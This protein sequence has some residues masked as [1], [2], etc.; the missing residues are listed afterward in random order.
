MGRT[1][2]GYT[3]SRTRHDHK[4]EN[5]EKIKFEKF[6]FPFSSKILPHEGIYIFW[7]IMQCIPLKVNRRFDETCSLHLLGSREGS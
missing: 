2:S 4:G 6:M 3:A 1:H 7:D 5:I